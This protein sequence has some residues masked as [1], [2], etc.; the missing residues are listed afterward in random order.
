[1]NVNT[2][3]KVPSA[4]PC[5]S[6]FQLYNDPSKPFIFDHELNGRPG[7]Y[8]LTKAYAAKTSFVILTLLLCE[9]LASKPPLHIRDPG[10]HTVHT[11]V[12]MSLYA[13]GMSTTHTAVACAGAVCVT[14]VCS[15]C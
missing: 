15:E 3:G 9:S 6:R 13:A 4:W 1:M 14:P 10:T 11:Y 2:F 5:V 7:V 8:E 12:A